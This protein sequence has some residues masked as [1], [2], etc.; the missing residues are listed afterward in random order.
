ME[1]KNDLEESLEFQ[2]VI[3]K[4]YPPKNPPYLPTI[5]ELKILLNAAQKLLG[6]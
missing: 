2:S 1:S 6:N 4:L 3:S 5:D